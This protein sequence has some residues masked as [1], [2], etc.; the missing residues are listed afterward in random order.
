M[1]KIILLG[2]VLIVLNV[3]DAITTFYGLNMGAMEGNPIV[4]FFIESGSFWV[5]KIGIPIII[6]LFIV[7][8][9]GRKPILYKSSTR[10]LKVM[11]SVFSLIVLW[12]VI[13]LIIE[14][15]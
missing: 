5:F 10:V 13:S 1:K 8:F 11:N 15:R 3:L 4:R 9:I 6:I 2:L 12:N 14:R 7:L